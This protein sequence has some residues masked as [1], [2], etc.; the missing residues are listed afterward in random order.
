MTWG[1]WWAYH[2]TMAPAGDISLGTDTPVPITSW[3]AAV[4]TPGH[5][6]LSNR[7]W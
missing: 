5:P 6:W 1:P 2:P 3:A 4:D 7:V